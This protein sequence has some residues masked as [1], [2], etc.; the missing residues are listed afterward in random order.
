[1]KKQ[2]GKVAWI[3]LVII[4]VL[5]ALGIGYYY[6]QVNKQSEEETEAL[7]EE[8]L[9]QKAEN[10]DLGDENQAEE[11]GDADE[12]ATNWKEVTIKSLGFE[13]TLTNNWSGYRW[14]MNDASE[15]EFN[16]PYKGKVGDVVDEDSDGLVP[17][18]TIKKIK[19]ADED[20]YMPEEGPQGWTKIKS[21]NGYTYVYFTQNGENYELKNGMM[22]Y[23]F[24]SEMI[25]KVVPSFK[26]IQ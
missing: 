14:E 1:M 12:T 16:I 9:E 18:L 15:V 26:I 17:V 5:G 19:A 25:D 4:V 7:Q 6:Y 3:I 2:Q 22:V 13:I 10:V 11:S 20:K 24:I 21:K 8:I 23:D